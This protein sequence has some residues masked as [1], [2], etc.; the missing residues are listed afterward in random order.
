MSPIGVHALVFVG[1]WSEAEATLATEG[2][3]AAGF[4]LI[5]IP[6]LDPATI[7][8]AATRRA[9][10]RA[11]L[12]AVCSLGLSPATDISSDDPDVVARG[13]RVLRDALRVTVEIGATYLG[14]VVY[15]TLGRYVAG[16][17]LRG[18]ANAV[19]VLA[20]LAE[21]ADRDGVRIGL[22]A[23]NR[24]ESNLVN[25]AE[26]ALR[27]I[28]D[29]GVDNVVVHLDTY[30]MNIEE[31]GMAAP[32]ERCGP[33]LGYVH[34]GESH[35]GYLGTGTVDF[36]TFF[37]A[38]GRVGYSGPIAFESF[39]TAV[40]H[41]ELSSTLAIWRNLWDDSADIAG[42]ARRF[43]DGRLADALARA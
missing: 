12:G 17:T 25:T 14:G 7:D 39:S 1:G 13:E 30:H 28:D 4:D 42:S 34:V 16:P 35:R 8:V 24:Y 29:I 43:I 36:D 5:E 15:G 27:L 10:E 33:Q 21:D 31:D 41:P 9:L 19:R 23:V 40:V 6:V 11:G 32:V 37:A 20:R 3:A 18:R 2:A 26:Q 22:E 38:L